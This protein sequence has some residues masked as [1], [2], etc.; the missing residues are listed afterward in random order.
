MLIVIAYIFIDKSK[1]SERVKQFLNFRQ[2]EASQRKWDNKDY[3]A[4]IAS[5][6]DN[7]RFHLHKRHYRNLSNFAHPTIDSFL[8]NRC[9][10]QAEFE[11]IPGTSLL[12]LGTLLEIVKICFQNSNYFNEEERNQIG[13]DDL[14]MQSLSLF[15]GLTL[16]N[17]E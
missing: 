2:F 16:K 8:L 10:E 3:A 5:L 11:M 17:Y 9:G 13:L 12:T 14:T 15:S 6:P 4:M 7:E 1:S